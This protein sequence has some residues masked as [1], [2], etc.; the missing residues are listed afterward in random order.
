MT[1][2]DTTAPTACAASPVAKPKRERP[3]Y[4]RTCPECGEVFTTDQVG[5]EFCTDAHRQAMANRNAARGKTLIPLAMGWRNGRGKAG[6]SADC[7][8]EM[9]ELLDH[10]AAE[11]RAA[12]RPNMSH[13]ADRLINHSQN[14]RWKDGRTGTRSGPKSKKTN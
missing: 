1:T 11:D 10:F 12:G 9:V 13:Y 3:T 2:Q 14:L 5:K 8:R 6:L 7:M 4:R